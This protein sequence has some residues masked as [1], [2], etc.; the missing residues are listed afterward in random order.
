MIVNKTTAYSDC[1]RLLHSVNLEIPMKGI[2]TWEQTEET[3]VNVLSRYEDDVWKLP[4]GLFTALSP[5]GERSLNFLNIPS[6]MRNAVRFAMLIQLH[7]KNSRGNSLRATFSAIVQFTQYSASSNCETLAD[8]TPFVARQY[9]EFCKSYKQTDGT[10]KGKN[11]REGALRLRFIGI[12]ILWD[13]LKDTPYA[14][15]HPWPESTAYKQVGRYQHKIPQTKVIPDADL[16]KIFQLAV[17]RLNG[18]DELL[19]LRK[20]YLEFVKSNSKPDH[21]K[22]SLWLKKHGDISLNFFHTALSELETSCWVIVLCTTGIRIHELGGI[23]GTVYRVEKDDD[24]FHFMMSESSKTHEGKTS[25]LC[26]EI[27]T[28]AIKIMV[29]IS[30]PLRLESEF[31]RT[32]ALNNGDHAEAARLLSISKSL[33]ISKDNRRQNRLATTGSGWVRSRIK[34]LAEVAGSDWDF[35]P[36]QFRRTFAKYVVHNNLGD[37][38]YLRDHFK[39]WS[40]DMTALYQMDELQDLELYDEIHTAFQE[41]QTELVGHWL[42]PNTPIAGG[43]AKNIVA[44]RRKEEPV[45]TYKNHKDMLIA[46]C[47][48]TSV[49]S[50]GIAWCTN[51][52]NGCGGGKCEECEH[53]II[54]D[55]MQKKWEAIY[56]QQLELRRLKADWGENGSAT[57]ER[58]ITRCEDVLASLGA[59]IESI[60]KKV[61]ENADI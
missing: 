2:V 18:A 29:R 1:E 37:L 25:W 27:T 21:S 15:S 58:T 24:T 4:R 56:E 6:E 7:S 30:E 28:Q 57:I 38:R 9:V 35:A 26:P 61:T 14:F 20:S 8:V 42:E 12:E 49:R 43:L 44:L 23:D 50:T 31:L 34:K 45:R 39:H 40:L 46:I 53:S 17:D 47:E 36:H 5:E 16:K 59:D 60:K 19:N 41:H 52:N 10:R 3:K 22:R 33:L 32:K 55:H 13:A 54:D 51:D 11:L 48:S